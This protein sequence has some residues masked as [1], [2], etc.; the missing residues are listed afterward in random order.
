L[1]YLIDLLAERGAQV[2][3]VAPNQGTFSLELENRKLAATI[4]PIPWVFSSSPKGRLTRLIDSLVTT[5]KVIQSGLLRDCEVVYSNSSVFNIG[6][7]LSLI[8]GVPHIWHLRELPSEHFGLRPDFGWKFQRLLLSRARRLLVG[9]RF[10]REKFAVWAPSGSFEVAQN[11][12]YSDREMAQECAPSKRR[13]QE[14]VFGVVCRFDRNKRVDVAIRAFAEVAKSYPGIS[15]RIYGD[16]KQWQTNRLKAIAFDLNGAS[17]IHFMGFERD[18]QKIFASINCL[19]VTA[20]SEAFGRTTVEAMSAGVPV[21]GVRS[22]ATQELVK[23]E[24]T[25]L[26]FVSGSVDSLANEMKRILDSPELF[27]RLASQSIQWGR[28]HYLSSAQSDFYWRIFTDLERRVRP[29][30]GRIETASAVT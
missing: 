14:V 30:Q 18:R 26:L 16:G 25:G 21:I 28:Q 29:S 24:E 7:Y 3:V 10:V 2:S 17:H 19:L 11:I 9:S 5:F 22:G 23:H 6:A 12:A 8:R 27:D 1:L 13:G 4:V 20:P 15:L